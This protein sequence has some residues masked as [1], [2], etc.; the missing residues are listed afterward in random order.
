[1][2]EQVKEELRKLPLLKIEGTDFYVDLR[3][4]EFRQTDNPTNVISFRNVQDNGDHTAV[5]Y[6]PKT[7]NA[8][9]GTWGEMNQR[10]DVK[11]VRLPSMMQL[12]FG[13]LVDLLNER[14]RESYLK[15]QPNK[16]PAIEEER[17]IFRSRKK[18]RG[19]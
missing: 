18:G 1:M 7:K 8:F 17:T 10:E 6:D 5:M 2:G 16:R 3:K 19:I 14:A 13:G 4:M 15:H 9:Q 12:D 11:L